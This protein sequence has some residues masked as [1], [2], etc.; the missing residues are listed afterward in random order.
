[1]NDMKALCLASPGIDSPVAAAMM[2]SR[3]MKVDLIH[4]VIDGSLQAME[5]MA[6]FLI[7]RHRIGSIRM[8]EYNKVMSNLSRRNPRY[9]CVLCKRMMYRISERI[10]RREGY[11]FLLTGENLGQVAS[12]TLTNMEVISSSVKIPIL[13]PLLCFDKEEIVQKAIRLGT[14]ELSNMYNKRCLYVP[15]SPVTKAKLE[16]CQREES[17][18]DESLMENAADSAAVHSFR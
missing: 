17:N 2:V 11:D 4:F 3:G 15:E 18:L 5:Q 9:Q 6:S 13:R 14:Y 7:T 12:Q 10:A 8:V 1:M 16:I